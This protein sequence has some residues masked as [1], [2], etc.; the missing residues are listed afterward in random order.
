MK[1]KNPIKSWYDLRLPK[2]RKRKKVDTFTVFKEIPNK[3]F[4]NIRLISVEVKND[5]N[6][7]CL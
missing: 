6:D 4:K 3:V 5:E 7:C 2:R 1:R